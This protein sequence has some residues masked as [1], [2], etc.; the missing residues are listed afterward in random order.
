MGPLVAWKFQKSATTPDFK[1]AVKAASRDITSALSA[2]IAKYV[3]QSVY[4][5]IA[6]I[7]GFWLASVCLHMTLAFWKLKRLPR[8]K[9]K[10]VKIARCEYA[11]GNGF[12]PPVKKDLYA[13]LAGVIAAASGNGGTDG[14]GGAA[15]KDASPGLPRSW[16]EIAPGHLVI[17]SEGPGNGWWDAVVVDVN[18]DMLTLH[19]RDFPWQPDVV[20]HR[21]SVALIKPA[22]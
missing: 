2:A 9:D 20:Q 14:A 13:T 19:W 7:G 4:W 5:G 22:Q 17:A 1:K 8:A 15:G 6:D 10:F 3:A 18:G 11:N 21:S 16:D 12:V